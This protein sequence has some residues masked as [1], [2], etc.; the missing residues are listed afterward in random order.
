MYSRGG[1]VCKET[2]NFGLIFLKKDWDGGRLPEDLVEEAGL[3]GSSFSIVDQVKSAQL[4]GYVKVEEQVHFLINANDYPILK[5]K[6]TKVFLAT[7][8]NGWGNSVGDS[9]WELTKSDS[10]ENL[11]KLV[12]DWKI[13][14][15]HDSFSFKFITDQGIWIEPL[16]PISRSEKNELGTK[17]FVFDVKRTGKDIL[18]F[19]LM[20]GPKNENLGNWLNQIPRGNFGYTKT[21]NG[22]SFRVFAP[23]VINVEL[24][25]YP[26]SSDSGNKIERYPMNRNQDGSWEINL[27]MNCEGL[28]YKYSIQQI[29]RS[30]ESK[31]FEKEVVD[32]YARAMN[33][34]EGPGIAVTV[35]PPHEKAK[36]TPAEKQDLVILETHVRDLLVHASIPLTA[37]ERM[38]FCGLSKWLKSDD[39]YLRKLGVNAIELQPIHE[40]DAR[41]KQEYHW[42]YMSVNFFAPASSYASNPSDGSVINEFKD[43]VGQFHDAGLAVIIDVV[44]NHVGIPAHLSFLDRELY[45]S[46]DENGNLSNHSGCGNDINAESGAVRKLV[47]DSLAAMVNDFEIDGFRFDLGELLGINLLS[48]IEAEL[49][50]IKPDLILIA[51]P[52]SFRGRLPEKINQTQYSLW[53]DNCREKL[54]N[55][56]KGN[57][58]ASEVIDLLTGSLD[59]QNRQ[60]WQSINYLESHDDLAFIDRICSYQDWKEGRPPTKV[61]NQAKLAIGLLLLSPGIPMIASGQDYLRSKQGVQNTYQRGDLNALNYDQFELTQDFHNWTKALISL[62]LSEDGELFRLSNFMH[63]DQYLS[64]IGPGNSIAHIILP[65]VNKSS[66]SY[67][68]LILANPSDD[69]I[70]ISLPEICNGKKVNILIGEKDSRLGIIPSVGLQVWKLT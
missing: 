37:S 46:T 40:F 7:N 2:K 45:F 34:R 47:I 13:V 20:E 59:K 69:E 42:G 1:Y 43:L 25:L 41:D 55:F 65:R 19:E 22:S 32:P 70:T 62:R 14:S 24:L 17:N 54:L 64:I 39:C 29:S 28:P 26:L 23:R 63:E 38:Q 33:G 4:G 48:E 36:F 12:I 66:S 27:S 30:G 11:F 49:L 56:V 44:Y 6:E 67:I 57:G 51:E 68:L 35:K 18:C 52:W 16:E 5:D 61:V 60:P 58:Q 10:D 3:I 31:V 9:K 53:S 21:S 15:I 50:S 8:F